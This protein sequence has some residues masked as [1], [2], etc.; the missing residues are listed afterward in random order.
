MMAAS[1]KAARHLLRTT[2]PKA[3]LR[4]MEYRGVV[5]ATMIYDALPILDIFREVDQA[6]LLGLMDLRG[7][8]QP[9]FFILRRCSR[10]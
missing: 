1:D 3:R 9:F 10:A 6:T 4:R 7:M 2:K 5:S 8:P